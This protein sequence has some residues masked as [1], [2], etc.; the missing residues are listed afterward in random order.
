MTFV[1]SS[2]EAIMTVNERASWRIART[3][4]SV[5]IR[6]TAETADAIKA[7]ATPIGEM[8]TTLG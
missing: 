3:P 5:T 4:W 8:H 6:E 7:V 1:E 2:F